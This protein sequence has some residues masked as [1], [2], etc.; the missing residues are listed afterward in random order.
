MSKAKAA[1]D[2]VKAAKTKYD[3]LSYLLGQYGVNN[4]DANTFWN[5]MKQNGWGQDDID[6]WTAEYYRREQEKKDER[7]KANGTT[8]AAT[9]RYERGADFKE[10]SADRQGEQDRQGREGRTQTGQASEE[11]K[12]SWP[13]SE[14][15]IALEQHHIDY[16][17]R[18]AEKRRQMA[19]A[20]GADNHGRDPE[21]VWRNKRDGYRAEAAA[22]LFFGMS[23]PWSINKPV[24]TGA[25]K[26]DFSNF[27]DVKLRTSQ[28]HR[29]LIHQ[30]D[31]FNSDFAYLLVCGALHPRYQIVGWCWGHEAATPDRLERPNPNHP[32]LAWMVRE[33]DPVMKSPYL[34]RDLALAKVGEAVV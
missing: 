34:L 32:L 25:Q 27:I 4:I 5:Q 19:E 24:H 16:V 23:V 3:T 10:Q 15:W 6:Q 13:M 28:H 33:R 8:R 14:I 12:R 7:E 2:A 30:D 17:D 20:V 18:I 1:K 9:A 29:L 21:T 31:N 26:I 22:R 11:A